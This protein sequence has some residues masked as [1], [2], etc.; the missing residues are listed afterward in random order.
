MRLGDNERGG[1]GNLYNPGSAIASD[2]LDTR[3]GCIGTTLLHIDC[4]SMLTTYPSRVLT[5]TAPADY[6]HQ[7]VP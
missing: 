5:I 1:E 3:S 7:E 2:R 6:R 4:I